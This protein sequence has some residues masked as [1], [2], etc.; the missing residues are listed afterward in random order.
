MKIE[1]P[2]IAKATYTNINKLSDRLE[3]LTWVEFIDSRKDYFIWVE[4]TEE[5]KQTLANIDKVPESF[6]EGV[7]KG[8]S[9][10]KTYAEFNSRKGFYEVIVQFNDKYGIV[11]TTF[12]K[13]ITKNHLRMLLEM[14]NHLDAYLLN[15]GKEIIDKQVIEN[16]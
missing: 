7:I 12:Q 10:R 3:Y 16:L 4:N 15:N 11:H 9:K 2:T 1:D 13:P 5:G 14:A 8:H 6:R